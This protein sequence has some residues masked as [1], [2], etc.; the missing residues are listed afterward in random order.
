[1]PPGVNI[2]TWLLY[3]EPIIVFLKK[4]S[5]PKLINDSRTKTSLKLVFLAFISQINVGHLRID[6]HVL[7]SSCKFYIA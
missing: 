2:L 6:G 1:M 4:F 7:V 5:V 3:F